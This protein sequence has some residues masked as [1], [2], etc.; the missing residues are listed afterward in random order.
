MIERLFS[1]SLHSIPNF[2]HSKGIPIATHWVY[3][4]ILIN[5]IQRPYYYYELDNIKKIK[6]EGDRDYA[7]S[8]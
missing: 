6:K 8:L 4:A 5:R 3:P 1:I 7:H 2:L